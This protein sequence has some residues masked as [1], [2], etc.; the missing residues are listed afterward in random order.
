M[1][2]SKKHKQKMFYRNYLIES[3]FGQDAISMV[4]SGKRQDLWTVPVVK[5]FTV[6]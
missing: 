6:S 5:T 4:N 3:I 2:A 1:Q